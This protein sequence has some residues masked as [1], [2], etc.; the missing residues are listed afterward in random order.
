M[1]ATGE[2]LSADAGNVLLALWEARGREVAMRDLL[3]HVG[4]SQ[5]KMQAALEGLATR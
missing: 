3:P 2:V 4:A 5:T 1:S